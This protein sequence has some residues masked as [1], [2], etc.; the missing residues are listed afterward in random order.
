M[1]L[2]KAGGKPLNYI[3]EPS[4]QQIINAI[5]KLS[6]QDK[7]FYKNMSPE[8]DM[9]FDYY[10]ESEWRLVYRDD[11]KS[12]FIDPK[13]Q[14]KIDHHAFYNNLLRENK[15]TPDYLIPLNFWLAVI[16]YPCPAVKILA[17]QD[18]EIRQLIAK[19]RCKGIDQYKNVFQQEKGKQ[20]K[21]KN[22]AACSVGESFM[23][24]MEIDLDT[25]SHF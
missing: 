17:E 12:S 6:D 11:F 1:F 20:E 15:R 21:L 5:S 24:P 9:N 13:D 8:E 2:V 25:M 3:H 10:S 16:I 23:M 22:L 7:I 14:T 18:E 19:T 4:P